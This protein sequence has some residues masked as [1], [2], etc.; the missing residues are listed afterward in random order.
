MRSGSPTL[1]EMPL[2]A[3]HVVGR[4]EALLGGEGEGKPHADGDGLA[5]QEAVGVAGEGLKRMAESMAEIEQRAGAALLA[6]VGLNDR[7]LGA[8][9]RGDGRGAWPPPRRKRFAARSAPAK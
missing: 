2:D 6:L 4:A 3:G 8:D 1:G 5:V 7:G 9:A